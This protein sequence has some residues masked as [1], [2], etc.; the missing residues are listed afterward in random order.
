MATIT[1]LQRPDS[2]KLRAASP[3]SRKSLL[4]KTVGMV[5]FSSYPEDPRPR[6]AAEALAKEGMRVEL[7]CQSND[8]LRTRESVNGIGVTRLPIRHYRGG[9][10]SYAYQYFGFTLLA[11]WILAWRTLRRRYDLVHVHNMPDVLVFSA[12]VPKMFGAKVILDQHDPMPELMKTIFNFGDD[13][14]AVRIIRRL[15]KWSIGFADRVVTVNAACKRIFAARSCSEN[16]VAVVM[17]SPDGELFPFR[18]AMSYPAVERSAERPFTIMYHGS[19]VERN[20]LE[21]A[22]EALARVR[23]TVPN[24]ELKICGRSTPFLEQVLNRARALGVTDF[25]RYMGAKRL[26]E[27]AAEIETCDVG[28]IPNQ[29]NAF[30]DINTPTRIFE[31]LALGKAVIAPL[32]PGIQDYFD[33]ESLFFFEAGDAEELAEKIELVYFRPDEA[34]ETAARGQ[35]IYLAHTWQQEKAEL[36]RVVTDILKES[37]A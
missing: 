18:S 23:K 25:I 28:V 15:E 11:G 14:L 19:L 27:L 8:K 6:R 10:L 24:A 34:Q 21:L 29:R 3:A 9:K 37:E 32:T 26:E 22:V 12:V 2:A 33:R 13:S 5:V 30:T 16:K 35:Q 4:G 1:N 17:N 36:V 20:G 7:I 31:Y